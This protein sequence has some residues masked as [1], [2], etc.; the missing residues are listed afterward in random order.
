MLLL[1]LHDRIR[2]K[3][4]DKYFLN[5]NVIAHVTSPTGGVTFPTALRHVFYPKLKG[6]VAGEAKKKG[7]MGC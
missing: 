5:V 2:H 4:P 1:I 7:L 6:T 3:F